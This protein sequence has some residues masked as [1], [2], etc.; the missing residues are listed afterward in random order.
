[1]IPTTS[2]LRFA[3]RFM[4]WIAGLLAGHALA[5]STVVFNEIHY[6]P[7]SAEA[8][9]EWLELHNQMAVNMDI[10]NWQL[11]GG[12]QFTFPEGTVVPGGG[13]LLVALNPAALTAATGVTNVTGP[14]TGRLSNSGETLELRNNNQRLMDSVKYGTDD[15]WP[16]A[17][18]GMGVTLAKRHPNL[19]STAAASWTMSAQ[20]GGTPGRANFPTTTPS[21][22]VVQVAS[23]QFW[24]F[25]NSGTDPGLAWSQPGFDDHAWKSAPTPFYGGNAPAPGGELKPLPGLFNTG[26]GPDGHVLPPGSLDPHY[27]VTAS[28]QKVTPPPPAPALVITGHPAWLPNDALSNWLGPVDPGTANVAAGSYRLRTAFDLTGFDA[29]TASLTVNVA[30]DNRLNDILINGKS[31][32]L[33][34]VDY[35]T[36]SAELKITSGF[37]PGTNTLEFLWANDSSS[38]NPAGFRSKL[39]GTARTMPSPDSRFASVE[40][41]T[42]FRTSFLFNGSPAET[43]LILRTVLDDGAV[44]YVNGTEILRS[45]LPDGPMTRT[46]PAS[47]DITGPPSAVDRVLPASLLR[48]GTNVLAIELH[49]AAAGLNDAWF[50]LTLSTQPAPINAPAQVVFNEVG[51]AAAEAPGFFVELVNP[52]AASVT[53]DGYRLLRRGTADSTFDLPP[54]STLAAGGF[55]TLTEDT[56][57]FRPAAGDALALLMPGQV[58]VADAVVAKKALRGR[59]PDGKGPWLFPARAT[60]GQANIVDLHHEVV[61]HEIFYHPHDSVAEPSS[62]GQWIELMNRGTT[63]AS[64]NGW[65]FDTGIQYAFPTGTEIPPGGYL[66]VAQQPDALRALHPGIN[67]LGP[68]TNSLSHKGERIVLKDAAGNPV[69][70]IH[71]LDAGRWP[72]GADGGGSSLELRNP[73]ADNSAPETWAASRE[74]STG[75]SPYTYSATAIASPGPNQWREFVLGLLDAGECLLDDIQVIESPATSPVSLLQ[76]GDFE[77]GATSWR[78][79][80]THRLS[81]VV[82]DPDNPANHVLHL[83]ATG[84]TEHMH[85]HIETTLASNRSVVNGRTYQI[86]FRAKWLAGDNQLNSRLYFNRVARTTLLPV[87]SPNGTPGTRNSTYEPNVGPTFSNLRHSPTVPAPGKPVT[88]SVEA[89]D[90]DGVT[91]ARLFSS[92][93]GGAWQNQPM[94]TQA[95][96]V[97]SATL[98]GAAAGTVVQFYVQATDA[99]GATANFPAAGPASRALYVVNDQRATPGRLH[100]FRILMTPADTALLHATTNVMSN[101]SVGATVVYDEEE[102]FYDAGVHLQSSERGRL[103]AGRVGFTVSFPPDHLFRGAHNGVS[104]DRSGGYT[105]VGA[106]QDEILLKHVIQHAGGVAGMYDD[107]VRVIPPRSDLTGPGLLILAKYGDVFLDSQF[108]HGSDGNEF[109]LEL[110]YSPT[111]TVDGNVQSPKVPQPDVVQGVDITNLGDDPEVYRWFFLQENNRRRNDYSQVIA[112]AKAMTRTGAA[113]DSEAHRL[114]D[115]DQWTRAIAFQILFGL[116]DA[117]PFDNQHNF[118]IYFRPED[119]RALPFLWD[120]DFN[121]GAAVNAPINRATGNLARLMAIPGNQRLFLGHLLDIITTTYN[122]TYLSPWITHYGGLVGQNFGGIRSYVDQRVKYVRSQLPAQV[123]FSVTSPSSG[124]ANLL[125]DTPSIDLSGQAW[126]NVHDIRIRDRLEVIEFKWPGTTKWQATV[127]LMLGSNRLEFLGYDFHG[128]L[129]ASNILNVT[130]TAVGGGLDGD[131]DGM[132]DAWELANGLD[133]R[134]PDAGL[135][136]DGDGLTGVQEFLAGTNPQDSASTLRLDASSLDPNGLRLSFMARAGR[137]YSVVWRDTVAG[138]PWQRLS[139]TAPASADHRVDLTDPAAGRTGTRFYQLTTPRLP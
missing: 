102:V 26:T 60:P 12:A 66:V 18:D 52:T 72:A 129:V 111:T 1:M 69:E 100:N 65:R 122:T 54:G 62:R 84:P 107:L 24:R 32:G 7:P 106:D 36:F 35:S 93:N 117:Y 21:P 121:F 6:H 80:G 113:L 29:A 134:V 28:A 51:A 8:D 138:A 13:Y 139:D 96:G 130:S 110:I 81:R 25:D 45:N 49:Q 127:P 19:P 74:S 57:G 131:G 71:Y 120:M 15:D 79:L 5:D 37:V 14:L 4:V 17:P 86:S 105:G 70:D 95:G 44:V 87:P 98:P 77:K 133:P 92:A 123:P 78:F 56:L 104:I 9:S 119:G 27:I 101:E 112:L 82:I 50:D 23:G 137:S 33:T 59:F 125:L 61:I 16:V 89:A 76:N 11:A 58:S 30:A 132:P 73:W 115:V 126:I 43:Q 34:Y 46:T 31:L 48:N 99:L 108:A 75:W 136:T 42:C 97:F 128:T 53:L 68:F 114:M 64:L 94:T 118:M 55:L 39:T 88:V 47:S 63:P 83:I 103:D 40:R 109:K 124:G 38:P 91:S 116:V 2:H 90:P 67:V 3:A 10:S 20:A 85:N 22:A 41:V 135:D